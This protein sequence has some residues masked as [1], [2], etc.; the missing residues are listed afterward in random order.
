MREQ[1]G[2]STFKVERSLFMNLKLPKSICQ[3][4]RFEFVAVKAPISDQ[5]PTTLEK[6]LVLADIL[7]ACAVR[8]SET[9]LLLIQCQLIPLREIS[10]LCNEQKSVSLV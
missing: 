9:I 3:M 8:L 6:C 5:L 4:W 1:E 2:K 10:K 7:K